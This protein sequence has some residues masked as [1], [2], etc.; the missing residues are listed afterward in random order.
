MA[1]I[2]HD[3]SAEE[4]LILGRYGD[5]DGAE[6]VADGNRLFQRHLAILGNSGR[7]RAGRLRC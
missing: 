7:G 4:R 5:G 6:A 2:A 1:C 3:V